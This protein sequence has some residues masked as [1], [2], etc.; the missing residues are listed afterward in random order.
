MFVRASMGIPIGRLPGL[1]DSGPITRLERF[2]TIQEI[3]TQVGT[4]KIEIDIQIEKQKK[5]SRTLVID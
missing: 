1:Y 2:E 4:G 5:F 3:A